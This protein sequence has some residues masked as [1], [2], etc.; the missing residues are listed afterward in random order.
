VAKD[1]PCSVLASVRKSLLD[2]TKSQRRCDHFDQSL[3]GTFIWRRNLF[4]A[5]AL[6]GK[7]RCKQAVKLIVI[8]ISDCAR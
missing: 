7:R 4:A 6:L 3:A 5:S 2:L 8:Q 1:G